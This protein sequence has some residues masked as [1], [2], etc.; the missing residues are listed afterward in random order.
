MACKQ[1]SWD[2]EVKSVTPAAFSGL[3]LCPET[4]AG[5]VVV[6][7]SVVQQVLTLPSKARLLTAI[8]VQLVSVSRPV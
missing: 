3:L 1:L 2:C 6:I 4:S 8:A 7:Q 5:G